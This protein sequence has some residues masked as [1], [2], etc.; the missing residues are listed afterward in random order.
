[1]N[2][3]IITTLI[4]ASY[5]LGSF[6]TG[7]LLVKYVK[8]T[9]I[10]NEG[11]NSTGATNTTR[12]LG[13]K[14]GAVA[15]IFDVLK[16]L[17]IMG[18]LVIFNKSQSLYIVNGI[19]ILAFYGLFAVIGHI[20]PV[21]LNFRGGKAVATSLGVLTFL[22][23]VFGLLAIILFIII[24]LI[25]KYISLASILSATLSVLTVLIF[26]IFEI[27]LFPNMV[28][29]FMDLVPLS[30]ALVL[31]VL[32]ILIVVKHSANIKRLIKGNELSFFKKI[33]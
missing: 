6:P 14:F 10:R 24:F 4:I 13:V 5:L 33:K 28:S 3:L 2:Y 9:D 12:V 18:L 8:K 32:D 1:M 31:V 27:K 19:N 26:S 16:G 7:Y 22:T 11:S 17:L 25:S 20:F 15:L 21:F 29:P 30:Y 23:P